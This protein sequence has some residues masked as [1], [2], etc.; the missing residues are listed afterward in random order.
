MKVLV[1]DGHNRAALAVTRS[2]GR[3]GHEVIVGDV[4]KHSL[5]HWSRY[6][7][8]AITYPDPIVESDAFIDTLAAIT[9]DHR[10]QAVVPV[11]DITTFL[12]TRHRDRFDRS[13]AVPFA[14]ADI[15]ERAA[16]KV[17]IV[18]TAERI[19]V[20]VPRSVVIRSPEDVPAAGLE[21]PLVI[22][23]WRS[24]IRTADGW[25]STAVT[26]A[27]T[28]DELMRDLGSRAP[29]EFPVMLQ[30]RIVGPGTGV[31]ALY[32]NGRAAALFSHRRIR[33]RPPWGGVSVLAES[34]EMCPV[35]RAYATRLLDELGWH[36]VAM[37][38]FKR[39]LRDNL[40]KLMEINGRFWG[41]LQL[42]IDAGV[43]FPGLLIKGLNEEVL[44]PQYRVGVQT[45]WFWGD[46][47]SLMLTLFGRRRWPSGTPTG[48]LRALRDFC[49]LAG[50]HLHYDNP[51]LD[52]PRPW[53]IETYRWFRGPEPA[54][55]VKGSGQDPPHAPAVQAR[56]P[57]LEANIDSVLNRTELDE[58]AW[59][60]LASGSETNTVFQTHQW[61]R[62]WLAAF[63]DECQPHLVTIREANRI[64]AVV[65]LA[66]Y[67]R[68]VGAPVLRFLGDGRADYCDV[69]APNRKSEVMAAAFDVLRER[70]WSV[71]ELNNIPAQSTTP[72]ILLAIAQDHGYFAQ[73]KPQYAC[74]AL[75]IKGREAEAHAILNKASL[76]R[77]FNYFARTGQ[78][79]CRDLTTSKEIEPYL[80]L[81]FQQ[82]IT[83]W[84]RTRTPSLF[85]DPRNRTFYRLLTSALSSTGWLLFSVVE[86]DGHPIALHYGFDY[87]SR[88]LWYKPSFDIAYA[89]HSPGTVMVKHLIQYAVDRQ[90]LELDFTLGDEPFKKRFTNHVR[91]TVSVHVY[92]YKGHM[93]IVESRRRLTDAMK[94][95]T[96]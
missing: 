5:A 53:L 51:K 2:L 17:D 89:A 60:T 28:R 84:R 67:E 37:V 82:H 12:V 90:K 73:V 72:D 7:S 13:C 32:Q 27:N 58:S 18:Q 4:Q 42:A 25:R 66:A 10:I 46:V 93:Q 22:K 49:R 48:R 78:L 33:E 59:N 91:R 3:A 92:R 44:T 1:L 70:E 56:T 83:R 95:G 94:A 52:D 50:R 35:A 68:R 76:R 80:D 21:F 6:C 96:R 79:T 88:I 30:E 85:E 15:I 74:P 55:V 64:V 77:R 29:Y 39:D 31:F 34:V 19:G 62:S 24:R 47:D 61:T 65:P 69:L 87:D 45:R 9:R 20:P 23:P 81:F 86:I 75:I 16:D 54:G 36:G 26:Y 8:A 41:S 14:D 63:A 40:P 43:D 57:G 11:S 71:V 38:E